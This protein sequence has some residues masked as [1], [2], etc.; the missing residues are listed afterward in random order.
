LEATDA[1]STLESPLTPEEATDA[2]GGGLDELDAVD[3]NSD[4]DSEDADEDHDENAVEDAE[5][6]TELA[7]ADDRELTDDLAGDR[8]ESAET[9]DSANAEA[10]NVDAPNEAGANEAGATAVTA[11]V[12]PKG[13]RATAIPPLK[14]TA[15]QQARAAARDAKKKKRQK[16]IES[17]YKDYYNF[18]EPLAKV[19]PHRLLAINRGERSQV[20]R[21]RVEA[22]QAALEREAL[23][24][25]V[26]PD[27]PHAAF[28]KECVSDA[29]SRLV[30]PNLERELRRELTDKAEHHAVDVFIR[31]LRNLLLQPPVHG[32]RVLAIDPGFR[33]GCKLAILDEFGELLDHGTIHIIGPEQHRQLC[34]SRLVELIRKY[35]VSVLAIGNGTACR[36]TEQMVAELLGTE[37]RAEGVEYVIVNEAGASVYSTSPIGREELPKHDATV[38]SAAS[39]G[40]RLLDPLSEL[41]K[42]NPANIGVGLYQNDLKAKHLRDSLE[43]VVESCVNY[44]GV[45]VNTAGPTLLRY[46]AGLNQLTARRL[47]EHRLKHGPFHNRE[48][49][50]KVPGFSDAMFIQAA[51]FLKIYG[52][53]NPLDA[54]W[55]HPE[56]YEAA[57]RLLD[58]I[59]SSEADL[60]LEVT[61]ARKIPTVATSAHESTAGVS[62]FG[63]GV[64]PVAA[65]ASPI[66]SA[67]SPDEPSSPE[68]PPPDNA[69]SEQLAVDSPATDP[70][71]SDP[72]ATDPT[73]TEPTATEPT[74]TEP[75][76]LAAS[77][78]EATASEVAAGP[79]RV[80]LAERLAGLN[81][82]SLAGELS[83]G[84][85]TLRDMLAALSRPRRDSREDLPPPVFRRGIVRL[86]DLAP[87]M[88]LSGTVLNVVD[89]GVF[90]DIGLSDSALIHISRLADRFVKDPHEVVGIGDVLKVWVVEV[91]TAR[92]RVS[93]TAIAPG[94]ERPR[95]ARPPRGE[96]FQGAPGDGRGDGRGDAR[97]DGRGSRRGGPPG[98][99]GPGQGGGQGAGPA[100]GRAPGGA[101]GRTGPVG[102]RPGGDRGGPQGGDRGGQR[103]GDRGGPGRGPGGPGGFGGQ[104]GPTG[105]T[106]GSNAGPAASGGG[107]GGYQGERRGGGRGGPPR[108]GYSNRQPVQQEF[109]SKKAAP[110][111][112]ITKGMIEGVEPMRTFGDLMQ[113]YQKKKEGDDNDAPGPKPKS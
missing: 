112:A 38:R 100:G 76:A 35:Q 83:I 73:A 58:R 88:E 49:L 108:G 62:V 61:P 104:R 5:D 92:R 2:Y 109:K 74:A 87:G 101:F 10:A 75:T 106:A 60:A 25:L 107:R 90:V 39:I 44:V 67:T 18:K 20:L 17:L 48:E 59:G 28:L 80:P 43:A 64:A 15:R 69:V 105:N 29:L 79:P 31:N 42:V 89:F 82:T 97:G 98:A 37:M 1:L 7:E 46:V 66:V 36:E 12:T 9:A 70:T 24:L 55:I 56:N 45:D 47:Y 6:D 4:S 84:V 113:F 41:V 81:V 91:D 54:T 11:T 71:A 53:D 52:G 65:D 111:R 23:E 93:L 77:V 3:S 16:L 32:R 63:G 13:L 40:R 86:E 110:D 68:S 33:S 30:V 57:R 78:S 26:K 96:G 14:L 34:R 94:S 99:Q 85:L 27:H 103:G 21:V 19:A 102:G 8:A 95:E 72:T 22:D 51:G 50:R